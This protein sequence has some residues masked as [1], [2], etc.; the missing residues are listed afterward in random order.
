MAKKKVQ[1][2][3]ADCGSE[4][5]LYIDLGGGKRLPSYSVEVATGKITC[6]PCSKKAK[7]NA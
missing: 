1:I 2:V 7:V 5:A 6:P 4:S 3:C